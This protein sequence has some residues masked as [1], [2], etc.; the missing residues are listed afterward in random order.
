MNSKIAFAVIAALLSSQVAMAKTVSTNITR[1]G[2]ANETTGKV[3]SNKGQVRSA[4][5]KS[6]SGV[7]SGDAA[8]SAAASAFGKSKPAGPIGSAKPV[9][10]KAPVTTKA[11]AKAPVAKA[12]VKAAQQ[13]APAPKP[14]AQRSTVNTKSADAAKSPAQQKAD[15]I[16]NAGLDNKLG[17][18][19]AELTTAMQADS[20]IAS[21]VQTVLNEYAKSDKSAET[22]SLAQEA[23]VGILN[24]SKL[25]S[26]VRDVAAA[27]NPLVQ[28]A[29]AGQSYV[30]LV[31]SNIQ[32]ISWKASA[33]RTKSKSALEL[34][35]AGIAGNV[36]LA[37]VDTVMQD[38]ANQLG[39]SLEE[40]RKRC[41]GLV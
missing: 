22:S 28:G 15:A 19:L 24:I 11:V 17:G 2:Q 6:A 33:S 27:A 25:D 21:R 41:P 31:N 12:P 5:K 16:Q 13:A 30:A 38:V 18:R 36:T 7:A 14:V 3:I 23:I 4:A 26:S 39:I 9:L 29:Q 10:A 20:D 32:A 34:A 1:N 35:N 8:A 37:K 40:L